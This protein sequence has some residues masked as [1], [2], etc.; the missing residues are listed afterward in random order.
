MIY[1]INWYMIHQFAD[2]RPGS[3]LSHIDL[4]HVQTLRLWKLQGCDDASNAQV[5]T[6]HVH[7]GILLAEGRVRLSSPW[8]GRETNPVI[9]VGYTN[10]LGTFNVTNHKTAF[11]HAL[12]DNANIC[13]LACLPC[14]PSYST[15]AFHQ[16]NISKAEAKCKCH[17]F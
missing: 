13:I 8:H 14:S 17:L 9:S 10:T 3:N 2:H 11:K 7:L 12:T 15:L 6:R 5:E 1:L 16:D 4:L